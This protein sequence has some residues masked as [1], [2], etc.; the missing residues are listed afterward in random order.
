MTKTLSI[1]AISLLASTAVQAGPYILAGTDADDH[2]FANASGN[3]DGW[4]FM[5]RSLENIGTGSGL[6]RG[7]K[8]IAV[9]GTDDGTYSFNAISSAFNLSSLASNG[10]TLTFLNG[11]VELQGFFDNT[12]AA[13]LNSNDASMLYI[14][15]GFNVSGGIS[16]SEQTVLTVNATAID[17]FLGSGG[18]LFSQSHT[19]G[20]LSALVPGL[21]TASEATTGLSLTSA[22]QLA[23]PGL[24]NADLS[25]GPYHN[26]FENYGAIPV[27]AVGAD[28]D[29]IILGGAGGSITDPDPIPTPAPGGLALLG[30]ALA[31]LGLRRAKG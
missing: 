31:G 12:N 23:F 19:Y 15:S 26:R 8:N 1:L 16:S 6:T 14:D 10:W 2:G 28:G 24:T 27:L 11:D 17:N 5:Q 20:W 21:T 7:Q 9:L 29:A 22:G 3:Q 18:G 30:I 25:A 4:F 13:G